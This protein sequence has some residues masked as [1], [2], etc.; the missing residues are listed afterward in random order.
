MEK[1]LI[2]YIFIFLQKSL[3]LLD[4]EKKKNEITKQKL[5]KALKVI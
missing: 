1:N 2:L 5:K 3:E 4:H